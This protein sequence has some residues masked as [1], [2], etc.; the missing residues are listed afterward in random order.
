MNQRLT[1]LTRVTFILLDL[2]ALNSVF[3]V[4]RH[5]IIHQPSNHVALQYANLNFFLNVAWLAA[6]WLNATYGGNSIGSFE[7]FCKKTFAAFFYFFGMAMVYLYLLKQVEISRIFMVSFM[8]SM[9]AAVLAV[10]LGHFVLFRYLLAKDYLV[11]RI[12]IIGHNN[13]AKELAKHLENE[14]IKT[15]I[16]GFCEDEEKVEELTHYP[17][18]GAIKN[19]MDVS[20]QY[21]ATDIYS[22]VAPEQNKEI[23]EFI[24]Q[25]D[26]A[27]IRFK[28]IPDLNQYI[29][30]QVHIDYM[31]QI[32][33]FS[34]RKEP[35]DDLANRIKKR[36]FDLVV[37]TLVVM[38]LLSWLVPILALLIWLESRG[39][40]FFIQKRTGINNKTFNCIKFRSMRMNREADKRQASRN[41]PR[42]T[43]LGRFLRKSNLD[44]L[45]QF[46]NVLMSDMSIVGPRP[47]MLKHT[48]DYS[49]LVPKY[50]VRQF[51]KPGITGWAQVS[52]WRGETR[53][54]SEMEGRVAHDLWYLEN[55]SLWLD[56]KI[57]F[58]T[59]VNM[60][61]GE[62]DAY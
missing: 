13:A 16:I 23:Y 38:L 52:G 15:S 51:L 31:G 46:F 56:A 3:W 18:V 54:V 7:R 4:L 58:M 47:H 6:S 30:H 10:R 9:G 41:D 14:P 29:R 57:I 2:L 62:R 39:P 61:R 35:L 37:A 24:Q 20:L 55:W 11:R 27:C 42:I 43:R 60:I 5:F 49:K 53:T 28:F 33:T 22:T 36:F 26:Q 48:E 1:R 21:K 19:T 32:A 34:I 12:L 17:V 8:C 50:M 40:V 44:E 45:P 59:A 25:A